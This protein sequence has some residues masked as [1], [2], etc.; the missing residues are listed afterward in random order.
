VGRRPAYRDQEAEHVAKSIYKI[1]SS[2]NRSVLDHEITLSGGG[3]QIKPLPVKVIGFWILSIFALF[4]LLTN[5]FLKS[6]DWYLL[7]LIVVWWLLATAFF[8]NYSKT[9]ELKLSSVPA[10]L[11]YLPRSARRV[12]TRKADDP[13]A[14]YAIAGIDGI[15]DSGFIAWGDGTVG[16]AYQVVGSASV[17]VFAQD[18]T[19]ILDRVDAFYRKVDTSAEYLWLTTKEPQR[20]YRQL[21]NLEKRNLA[22][23][24]DDPELFELM[25]EQHSIL[26]DYVGGSFTSI[27]QYLVIKAD[28]L[29]ALR[30]AHAVVRA[31]AEESALMIK[32][33]TQLDGDDTKEMFAN[34][35][36]RSA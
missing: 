6:A 26:K 32:Q 31:E 25:Q 17:L 36:G 7:G 8:G 34:F 12:S 16:Q 19:S 20:V 29:E 3:L 33:L 18:K 14:F 10:L 11:N 4:W 5:T 1:P 9:K 30:R 23:N 22:L 27:H 13:S 24:I 15:D 21:G 35:Y 28:N 2:L